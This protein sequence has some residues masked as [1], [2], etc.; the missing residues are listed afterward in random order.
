MLVVLLA[1][2]FLILVNQ[3]QYPIQVAFV[4]LVLSAILV[5]VQNYELVQGWIVSK[6]IAKLERAHIEIRDPCR[7]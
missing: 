7:F 5:L 6:E 4:F 1:P 2:A 3:S